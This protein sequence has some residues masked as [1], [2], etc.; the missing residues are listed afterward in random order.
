MLGRIMQ[1]PQVVD[2]PISTF[3]SQYLNIGARLVR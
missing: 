2:T 3:I 1:T